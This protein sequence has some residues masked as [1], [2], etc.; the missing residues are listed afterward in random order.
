MN[1]LV[2]RKYD[3]ER[4]DGEL[5]RLVSTHLLPGRTVAEW[6]WAFKERPYSVPTYVACSGDEIVGQYTVS[7]ISSISSGGFKYKAAISVDSVV[8]PE[9]RNRGIF[10]GLARLTYKDLR[11]QGYHFAVACS[12]QKRSGSLESLSRCGFRGVCELEWF[13]VSIKNFY[14]SILLPSSPM[15]KVDKTG[16]YI[17]W[18]FNHPTRAYAITNFEE[19]G[20]FL[21]L[22]VELKEETAIIVYYDGEVNEIIDLAV[23]CASRLGCSYLKYLGAAHDPL[24][25]IF[26]SSLGTSRSESGYTFMVK[27]LEMYGKVLTNPHN[28]FPQGGWFDVF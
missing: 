4:D 15:F 7:G 5:Y 14:P 1:D 3:P 28:W 10:S 20:L 23:E 9:Y 22:R 27:P 21:A 12:P 2:F 24:S 17:K 19:E 8:H 16:E 6:K 13:G 25:K 11:D 18:R 26:I